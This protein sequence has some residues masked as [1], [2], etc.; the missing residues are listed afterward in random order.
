MSDAAEAP[1]RASLAML[2]RAPGGFARDPRFSRVA[3]PSAPAPAPEPREAAPD[4]ILAAHAAGYDQGIAEARAEAADEMAAREAAWQAL[5]IEAARLDAEQARLLADRLRDTVIALCEAALGEAALDPERL[6][7]RVEAAAAMLARADD[8]RV[9]RLHPDDCE[10]V[11][12]RLP[13]DWAFAPDPLM[14]RGALRIEGRQ[15]GVEDGPEQWHAALVEA[16][17]SC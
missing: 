7:R 2:A 5:S 16:L 15:G 3:L 9:I 8:D 4:P 14:P 10:L 12:P 11:R 13:G 17:R 1:V 6:A